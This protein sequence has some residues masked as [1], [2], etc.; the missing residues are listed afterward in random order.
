MYKKKK[1]NNTLIESCIFRTFLS[2]VHCIDWCPP[3][4]TLN[5]IE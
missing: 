2:T 1:Q 4:T 3:R 5:T